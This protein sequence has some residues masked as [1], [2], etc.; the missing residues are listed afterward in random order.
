MQQ[1]LKVEA[2][3]RM[4]EANEFRR[5]QEEAEEAAKKAVVEQERMR[6]QAAAREKENIHH[7]PKE[8]KEE[9]GLLL[10]VVRRS[11]YIGIPL[12][13]PSF[14]AGFYSQELSSNGCLVSECF[15]RVR[16]YRRISASAEA[17]SSPRCFHKS[18]ILL[19]SNISKW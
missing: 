2:E 4:K 10:L 3:R 9:V 17:K 16:D 6:Q 12:K 8:P 19:A 13:F 1:R 7:K 15:K 11:V 14:T 18:A 5:Q